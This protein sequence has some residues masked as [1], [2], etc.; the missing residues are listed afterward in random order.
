MDWLM[1]LTRALP[2]LWKVLFFAM[3]PIFELRGAIPFAL[4]VEK[5][6]WPEAYLISVLGNAIP[7]IPLLLFLEPAEKYLGRWRPFRRFF[8][9]LFARTRKR[10]K[11]V[12]RFKVLGLVLFVGIPLPVTGAWTGCAAAYIFGVEKKKALPAILFGI[13]LAGIV[14]TLACKGVLTAGGLFRDFRN[15]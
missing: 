9:W 15:H 11:L 1:D 14:V 6:A 5:M 13:L 7:V 2:A 10:G 3:L 12:D 8:D 4:F